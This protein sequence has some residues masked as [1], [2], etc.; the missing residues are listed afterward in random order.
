M[1]R[2]KER[3]E[4]HKRTLTAV[5]EKRKE[6]R[7]VVERNGATTTGTVCRGGEERSEGE[8]SNTN[9]GGKVRLAGVSSYLGIHLTF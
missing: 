3:R 1:E 6:R 7:N 2:T 5:A 9:K 4:Q 8:E